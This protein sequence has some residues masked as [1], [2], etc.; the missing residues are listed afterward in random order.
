VKSDLLAGTGPEMIGLQLT[1][2]G[3]YDGEPQKIAEKVCAAYLEG[4]GKVLTSTPDGFENDPGFVI[5]V[6]DKDGK[7]HLCNATGDAMI[8]AFEPIGDPLT[9]NE[10]KEA[11]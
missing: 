1:S 8:W 5:F 3:T 11:S 10:T 6:A 7:F 4:G 9:F 2:D